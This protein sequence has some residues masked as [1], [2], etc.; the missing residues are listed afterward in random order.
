MVQLSVFD[1]TR[2]TPLASPAD[3]DRH[4]VASGATGLGAGS[5]LNVT[6]SGDG[7]WISKLALWLRHDP[8]R[9]FPPVLCQADLHQARLAAAM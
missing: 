4:L 9:R 7:A 1:R 6:F 3:V 5:D 8:L 2:T